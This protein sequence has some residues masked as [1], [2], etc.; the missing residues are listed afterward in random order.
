MGLSQDS[1]MGIL[2]LKIS[3]PITAKMT[4][5]RTLTNRILPIFFSEDSKPVTTT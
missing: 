5:T 4:N 2:T 1:D 3:V